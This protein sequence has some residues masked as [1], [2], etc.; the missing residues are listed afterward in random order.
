MS[1]SFAHLPIVTDGLIFS[2]DPYNRKSYVSG[3]TTC[4][5]LGGVYTGGTLNNGV[6]YDDFSWGFNGTNQSIDFGNILDMGTDSFTISSWVKLQDNGGFQN[7]LCKRVGSGIFVGYQ[8]RCQS[9]GSPAILIDGGTPASNRISTTS[10]YDNTWHNICGVVDRGVND[11]MLL[12]ID[13]EL[14]TTG[15]SAFLPSSVGSIDNSASLNIGEIGGLNF[16]D[17]SSSLN[18]IY[19]RVL[20]P[21]E[22]KQNYNTIKGRFIRYGS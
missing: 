13:G 5:I 19:N 21:S 9:D 22:I 3:D 2:V 11:E 8:L 1:T 7:I 12:Y 20:S 17:G 10:I 6:T 14:D 4:N 15:T 18:N 16:I